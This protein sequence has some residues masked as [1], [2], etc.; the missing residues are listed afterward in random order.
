VGLT[1]APPSVAGAGGVAAPGADVAHSSSAVA[2]TENGCPRR[3]PHRAPAP[4]IAQVV[5]FFRVVWEKHRAEAE[6]LI[7]WNPE[8]KEYRPWIPVQR[9]NGGGVKSI[10]EAA[11]I[12][13]GFQLVGSL[14]QFEKSAIAVDLEAFQA[15]Q[16][17][18][19]GRRRA[20][21]WQDL[22]IGIKSLVRLTGEDD[23]RRRTTL[24]PRILTQ[25][26]I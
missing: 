7:L 15:A 26:P 17:P 18:L 5:H 12:P 20:R 3:H 6:V 16:G 4:F 2:G 22:G 8:L 23:C 9:V 14:V 11:D 1:F 13:E 10:Y 24:P 25:T 19:H 21:A